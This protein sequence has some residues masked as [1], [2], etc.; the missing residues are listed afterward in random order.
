MEAGEDPQRLHAGVR[1]SL[2]AT[3]RRAGGRGQGW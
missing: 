1:Q 3:A 2:A